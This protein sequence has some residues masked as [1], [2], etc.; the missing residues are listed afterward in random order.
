M[1]AD[2]V[3]KLAKI[4]IYHDDWTALTN[5]ADALP[6]GSF[7][8]VA[9]DALAWLRAR[10]RARD[11]AWPGRLAADSTLPAELADLAAIPAASPLAIRARYLEGVLL[12]RGGR[13]RAA[14]TAFVAV[15]QAVDAQAGT[16][17]TGA[18][19]TAL[20]RDRDRAVL[21]M[22]ALAVRA[23]D[24]ARARALADQVPANSPVA[25]DARLLALWTETEAP[26]K[27]AP[28]L[29][30]PR[31]A[32]RLLPA[33]PDTPSAVV[34]RRRSLSAAPWWAWV[35]GE[36]IVATY[37]S[38]RACGLPG[39]YAVG[40]AGQLLET[41]GPLRDQLRAALA[42]EDPDAAPAALAPRVD[43][44][45]EERALLRRLQAEAALV[46]LQHDPWRLTVGAF[47]HAKI[48]AQ[49]VRTQGRMRAE[50][51][52]ALAEV[53]AH[54]TSLLGLAE[55]LKFMTATDCAREEGE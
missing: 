42:S 34:A 14:M 5:L 10:E 49:V 30:A 55:T 21:A 2:A 25:A 48:D 13:T 39:P 53:E 19:A 11:P 16:R 23:G 32:R 9:R 15:V 33:A 29:K 3:E 50:R 38:Q 45:A 54:L 26:S 18:R 35:E 46:D 12:A 36:V 7:D 4:A 43:V 51:L 17:V 41:Y 1:R 37:D 6:P 24:P 8:G 31:G 44:T 40:I 47:V 27:A 52:A 20:D 22:A 28:R